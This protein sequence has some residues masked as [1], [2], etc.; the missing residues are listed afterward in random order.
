MYFVF[1]RGQAWLIFT[2]SCLVGEAEWDRG[3]GIA[4]IRDCPYMSFA[5]SVTWNASQGHLRF[6]FSTFGLRSRNGVFKKHPWGFSCDF[7]KPLHRGRGQ[8]HSPSSSFWTPHLEELA[9][10][11]GE[12]QGAAVLSQWGPP[13][14]VGGHGWAGARDSCVHCLGVVVKGRCRW[15]Q[16]RSN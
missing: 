7:W 11:P 1:R 8:S 9:Q 2:L 15:I 6:W 10:V 3:G 14:G 4:S 12:L 16:W 13:S 5:V